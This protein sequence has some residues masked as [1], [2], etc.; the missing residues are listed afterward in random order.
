MSHHTSTGTTCYLNSSILYIWNNDDMI[1]HDKDHHHHHHHHHLQKICTSPASSEVLGLIKSTPQRL[2][3]LSHGSPGFPTEPNGTKRKSILDPPNGFSDRLDSNIQGWVSVLL[4]PRISLSRIFLFP[5]VIRWYDCLFFFCWPRE[6]WVALKRAVHPPAF[7]SD[8]FFCF[9]I[10]EMQKD[11]K[12]KA[13]I[14]GNFQ[15]FARYFWF[16]HK[17]STSTFLWNLWRS[18]S[19]SRGCQTKILTWWG[20][21]E[22]SLPGNF[23]IVTFFGMVKTWPPTGSKGHELN[24]LVVSGGLNGFFFSPWSLGG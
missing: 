6:K 9:T 21:L 14:I 20:G 17:N 3:Q 2:Q 16:G 24:H 7:S 11:V 22:S 10:V 23:A 13:L 18:K 19:C 12:K 15:I 4:N 8:A 5:V 1:I